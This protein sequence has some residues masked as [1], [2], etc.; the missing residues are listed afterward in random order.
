MARGDI[1]SVAAGGGG[2]FRAE[3]FPAILLLGGDGAGGACVK[4]REFCAGG[5]AGIELEDAVS[6]DGG[7]AHEHEGAA[8]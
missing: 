8:V 3:Y 2:V 5:G 4:A 7:A 6:G 1:F